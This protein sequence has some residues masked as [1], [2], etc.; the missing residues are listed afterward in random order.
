M[1]RKNNHDHTQLLQRLLKL[2]R[3]QSMVFWLKRVP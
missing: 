1:K 2:E 3:S